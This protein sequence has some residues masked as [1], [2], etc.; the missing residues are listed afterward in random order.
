MEKLVIWGASSHALVVVD[1]IRLKRQYHIV[2][3]L[4]DVNPER[5][6]HSFE[7]AAIRGGQEQLDGLQAEGVHHLFLAFGDNASRLRLAE[8][9]A[10]RGFALA[11]AIHPRATVATS[12]SIGPGTV[13]T[14]GAVVNPH[15]RVGANVIVNTL[16][17]VEHECVVEDGA[18]L[19]AGVRLGGGS[20]VRRGAL[21]E[22][23]AIVAAGIEIGEGSIVGAGS[24]VLRDVEAGVLV[25]GVP[26]R[27]NRRL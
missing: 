21:I 1:I 14:A 8:L 24:V 12:A 17:S 3:Y 10:S 13:V 5:K 6:G 18:Q 23:G 16:A 2:G 20:R 15:A 7:D 9:V 27:L 25:H 11:T 4:D 22:L 19:S 26:A